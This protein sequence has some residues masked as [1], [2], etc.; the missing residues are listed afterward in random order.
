VIPCDLFAILAV[1]AAVVFLVSAVILMGGIREDR[2]RESPVLEDSCQDGMVH[3]ALGFFATPK[4]K[5]AASPKAAALKPEANI[6]ATSR[7]SRRA[8]S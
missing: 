3:T 8:S 1:V 2:E 7:F 5:S 6:P 4:K